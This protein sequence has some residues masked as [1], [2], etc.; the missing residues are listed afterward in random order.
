MMNTTSPLAQQLYQD[1]VYLHRI[2][3]HPPV[4]RDRILNY[5]IDRDSF[6]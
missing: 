6:K 2:R 5:W 4:Q 3:L 1:A